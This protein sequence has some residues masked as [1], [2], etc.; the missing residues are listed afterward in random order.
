MDVHLKD[1]LLVWG[2]YFKSSPLDGIIRV[3]VW[4]IDLITF[5]QMVHT[6]EKVCFS[7]EVTLSLCINWVIDL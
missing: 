1:L 7:N 4:E 5:Q 6:A 2:E 3:P